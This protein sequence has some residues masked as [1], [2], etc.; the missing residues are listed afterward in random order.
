MMQLSGEDDDPL[1]KN[2]NIDGPPGDSEQMSPFIDTFQQWSYAMRRNMQEVIRG[3]YLGPYS[4]ACKD[5]LQTLLD[6]GISHIVC[7]R[8]SIEAHFIKPN[9]PDKFKYLV[10]DIADS[11][12]EN[13][14]QHFR[15]VKRFIDEG[16]NSG[17]RVLVHGNAGM[18]RSAALVLAY[19]METFDLTQERAFAIVLK[20]RFC[21][22]PNSGF[23]RQLREFEPIY[24]A[25]R[26]S[27]SEQIIRR[28]RSLHMTDSDIEIADS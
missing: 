24:Q 2:H 22:N 4:A 5:K 18:S 15:L 26:H 21:V 9:F 20:R 3:L 13:I 1:E 25:Q 27:I 23:I 8:Q 6:C 19:L 16:L 17:G 7:V 10:L 12:T 14:I 28:K 11:K